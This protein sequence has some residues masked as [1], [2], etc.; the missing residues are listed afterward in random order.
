MFPHPRQGASGLSHQCAHS[1]GQAPA[2]KLAGPRPSDWKQPPATWPP[3]ARHQPQE[4]WWGAGACLLL[5]PTRKRLTQHENWVHTNK[6]PDLSRHSW[7]CTLGGIPWTLRLRTNP[8]QNCWVWHCSIQGTMLW[9]Q[10]Q[11]H[12]KL[13]DC[14]KVISPSGSLLTI[15]IT[16]RPKDNSSSKLF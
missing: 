6:P 11:L 12:H 9:F 3:C 14:G 8:P 13:N 10:C 1:S 5:L 15:K 2:L 7:A 4:S 16:K